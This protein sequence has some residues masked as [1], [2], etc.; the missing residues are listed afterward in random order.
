MLNILDPLI[1]L[2]TV[3]DGGGPSVGASKLARG[4]PSRQYDVP[5]KRCI[6]N[7]YG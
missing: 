2:V 1:D 3:L 7:I 4:Y 5:S 6:L